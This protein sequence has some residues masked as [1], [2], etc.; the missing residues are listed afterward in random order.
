[1]T[2]PF[3]EYSPPTDPVPPRAAPGSP[4]E[5]YRLR[6]AGLALLVA[7][8]LA[9]CARDRTAG[10]PPEPPR[11]PLRGEILGVARD[12]GLLVVHHEEIPG[13]M[14]AMTMDFAVPGADLGAFR[15]GQKI[16]ATLVEA[17]AG[18][19]RLEGIRI[20]D[21]QQERD[22][23]A[24]ALALRQDTHTRGK[25]AYR[26]L[27]ET[28]P[29]FALA[30]QDG[31]VVR[32]E[33]FRGKRVVLNFIFTRCPVPTMCPAATGKMMALQAAAKAAGLRDLE[34]VSISFDSD[35]DTPPVLKK[36]AAD[37]GIDT[38]NFSFLTGS[39]DA[40]ADLLRQFGVYAIPG[41]NLYRHTLATILVGADGKIVH[42][43]D[44]SSWSP[45]DFLRLLVPPSP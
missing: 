42:R 11:H 33:H 43:T 41:E 13:Y 7:L 38:S 37:R 21:P 29:A 34:L 3:L 19:F 31:A 26:E 32:F 18:D 1:M 23:A 25:H 45:D 35:Y 28:A 22:L 8:G 5:R 39:K 15:A 24:A 12:R 44:E 10:R 14:P 6:L 27:G 17:A 20:L 9:G 2:S 36:Y 30:N 40:I 16:A 4:V